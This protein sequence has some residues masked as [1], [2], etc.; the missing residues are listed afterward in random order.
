MAAHVGGQALPIKPE[1]QQSL[2]TIKLPQPAGRAVTGME[3][4]QV[5]DH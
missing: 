3:I 1:K 2:A 5:S 4:A